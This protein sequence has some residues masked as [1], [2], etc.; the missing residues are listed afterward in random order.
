[1]ILPVVVFISLIFIACSPDSG[2]TCSCSKWGCI[3]PLCLCMCVRLRGWDGGCR[4]D[5][6]DYN[7]Q[8]RMHV[9]LWLYRADKAGALAIVVQR[10]CCPCLILLPTIESHA[11]CHNSWGSDSSRIQPPECPRM[12]KPLL[13]LF[14]SAPFWKL[15][16]GRIMFSE[17]ERLS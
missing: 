15:I 1:M 9:G 14:H 4:W 13:V 11:F 12:Q 16:D 10:F 5:R 7:C 2:A 6:K 3:V 17:Q 8:E